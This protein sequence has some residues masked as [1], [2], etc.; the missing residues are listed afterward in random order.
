MDVN[1]KDY[2]TCTSNGY[3]LFYVRQYSEPNII[4][5]EPQSKFLILDEE[6]D[7]F[8]RSRNI[9]TEVLSDLLNKNKSASKIVLNS[10]IL[11]TTNL[12][13]DTSIDDLNLVV[14]EDNCDF[15]SQSM[16][17]IS[18][19]DYD[20]QQ[21]NIKLAN[22]QIKLDEIMEVDLEIEDDENDIDY[23]SDFENEFDKDNAKKQLRIGK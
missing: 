8:N 15:I 7:S 16:N 5:L 12:N 9:K 11:V 17:D 18:I 23:N 14:N 2:D 20:S 10:S 19:K 1:S 21:D 4:N 22:S 6:G 3:L 13:K